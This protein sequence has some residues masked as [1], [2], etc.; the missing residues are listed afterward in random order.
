M[1]STINCP[2]CGKAIELTESL[3]VQ[4]RK[5]LSEEYNRKYLAERE[6]LFSA[7]QIKA[8][9]DV[10]L[11]REAL[12]KELEE[13]KRKEDDFIKKELDWRKKIND[14]EE[15]KK[16]LELELARRLDAEREKIE[17]KVAARLAQEHHF[18][19]R[20]KDK[21]IADMLK[22]IE[23]LKRKGQQG[24][25]QT[26]GE[27]LELDLEDRLARAFPTDLIE[28][29]PKGVRGADVVQKVRDLTGY[30]SGQILWEAK[31]TKSWSQEWPTKLKDDLRQIKANLAILVSEVLPPGIEGFGLHQAVWVCDYDS[32]LG[33]AAALRQGIIELGKQMVA[34]VGKEEKIEELYNYLTSAEFRR[35]IEAMVENFVAMKSD[36]ER[37]RRAFE[38]LWA[39][40][41]TQIERMAKSTTQLYGKIQGIAGGELPAIK[42]L[43]LDDGLEDKKEEKPDNTLFE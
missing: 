1:L 37:E 16:Q 39:R 30:E 25:M 29:V 15:Q 28:A 12:K 23:E 5:E 21:K 27:V 20:E 34:Q 13:R 3:T 10:K 14:F 40:R 31:R 22:T 6:K 42:E 17:E 41:E 7:A 11:E 2:S 36:L 33:L 35:R 38:K 26:Q 8:K 18:K 32:M 9:D 43:E 4:L 24:S 19:E